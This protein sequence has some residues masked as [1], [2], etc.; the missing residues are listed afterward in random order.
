MANHSTIL[1]R[2]I[3]WREEPGGLQ[4][5][6]C[7][8][9]LRQTEHACVRFSPKS[10]LGHDYCPVLSRN[11]EGVRE[12]DKKGQ[13]NKCP[14]AAGERDFCLTIFDLLLYP[15]IIGPNKKYLINTRL[16]RGT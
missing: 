2:R 13:R 16:N 1:A 10:G 6:G 11:S 15:K 7:Q 12:K 4:P 14:Q 5:I 3:P 9:Q 8:T